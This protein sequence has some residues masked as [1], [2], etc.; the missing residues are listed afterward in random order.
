VS[1]ACSRRNGWIGV[2][3]SL[4]LLAGAS[5]CNKNADLSDLDAASEQ[6]RAIMDSAI[7]AMGRGDAT[8]LRDCRGELAALRLQAEKMSLERSGGDLRDTLLVVLDDLGDAFDATASG[9]EKRGDAGRRPQ[10]DRGTDDLREASAHLERGQR[11][12]ESALASLQSYGEI[13]TRLESGR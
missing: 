5:A 8:G 11:K 9:L 2:V 3:L 12:L 6:L 7:A 1:R 13:R 4:V 10:S